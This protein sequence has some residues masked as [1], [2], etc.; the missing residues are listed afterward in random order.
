MAVIGVSA[1]QI[2]GDPCRGATVRLQYHNS[3]AAAETCEVRL[4][5]TGE[6]GTVLTIASR[7]V[8]IHGGDAG[9]LDVAFDPDDI[10]RLTGG[11]F[12][13]HAEA[14][15]PSGTEI[16]GPAMQPEL[17][18]VA[19]GTQILTPRGYRAA[20]TLSRGDLVVTADGASAPILLVGR[21]TLPA[22][23]ATE[24]A[25]P[26]HIRAGALGSGQPCRDCLMAPGQAVL[27]PG[28]LALASALVN[29]SSI[30]RA[31]PGAGYSYWSFELG[32]HDLVVADGLPCDSL[33]ERIDHRWL[34]NA[35]MLET[36]FP[37][38]RPAGQMALPLARSRRQLPGTVQRMLREN[39]ALP[40]A[41]HRPSLPAP[42]YP[43]KRSA[44]C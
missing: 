44:C 19:T 21:Q 1:P 23:L 22:F 17:T 30:R 12:A 33:S 5:A 34:D 24:T 35:G 42:G 32:R 18:G 26:I 6:D 11:P 10:H 2:L 38:G 36:L 40:A 14:A 9:S 31:P 4:L 28:L 3:S 15:G 43:R 39:A 7:Q 13:F 8:R 25:R 16:A 20:E 37:D 27:L 29:G 41:R